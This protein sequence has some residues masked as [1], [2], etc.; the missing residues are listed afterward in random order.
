MLIVV[1]TLDHPLGPIS[2]VGMMQLISD[3]QRA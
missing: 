3:G 2:L 1:A